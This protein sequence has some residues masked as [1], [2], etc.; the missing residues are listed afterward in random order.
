M[1]EPQ[2]D[3]QEH[4]FDE[5]KT[6]VRRII[7]MIGDD[8]EREGLRET[9]DRVAR[10]WAELFSGYTAK[11]EDHAKVFS[12]TYD[13]IVAVKGIDYFSMCEHHMLPFFGTLSIAYLP[14]GGGKVLGVSKFARIVEV[15]SRRLQIQE[16][17]TQQ[18]AQAIEA[19][20]NPNG[21]AVVVEG[22]HLCMM[23][24]GVKQQHARMVTS[25][26]LGAFRDKPEARAEVLNLIKS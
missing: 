22:V 25:C 2:E 26:M 23:A 18:I 20:T 19:A 21:V 6:T 16:Q 24:R 7:Q 1:I 17:M 9:P 14:N 8:P 4:F 13:E 10:S 12:A 5:A 15:F 11:V 3:F